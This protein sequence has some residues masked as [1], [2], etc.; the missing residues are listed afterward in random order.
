MKNEMSELQ[1]HFC[2]FGY[3]DI[4]AAC[5]IWDGIDLNEHDLFEVMLEFKESTWISNWEDIDSVYCILEKILQESRAEIERLT[6]YDF[7]ND[8]QW[9]WSEIYTHWNFMCSCYDYWEAAMLELKSM[10]QPHIKEL[11]NNKYVN[12]FLTEVGIL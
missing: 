6:G 10:I 5:K 1:G 9:N 7:I 12:Y 3:L 8:F 11:Q 4:Q 2:P